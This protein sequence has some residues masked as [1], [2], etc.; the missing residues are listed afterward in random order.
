MANKGYI[1]Q[2]L[3]GLPLELRAPLQTAFHYV[4]DNWRWKAAWAGTNAKY[5]NR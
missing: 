3:N 5:L 2:L 1:S 4:M